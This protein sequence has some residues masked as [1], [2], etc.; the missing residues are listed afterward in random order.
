MQLQLDKLKHYLFGNLIASGAI[1]AGV[2]VGLPSDLP[3]WLSLALVTFVG[4]GKE[5]YDATGRGTPEF[6][7]FAW[8]VAGWVS[9]AAVWFV[10]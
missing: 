8:T 7:D 9:V 1:C 2:L 5:A 4:A 10:L 3:V 6:A